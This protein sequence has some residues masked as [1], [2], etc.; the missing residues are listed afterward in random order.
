MSGPD[1]VLVVGVAHWSAHVEQ[2][3]QILANSSAPTIRD[4]S[5]A[6][7][8]ADDLLHVTVRDYWASHPEDLRAALSAAGGTT[9]GDGGVQSRTASGVATPMEERLV[10]T[11]EEAAKLLGISRSFAYEAVQKGDIPS[12]R[13]GR[14]ILVPK[15]RLERYLSEAG[16]LSPQATTHPP[17]RTQP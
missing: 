11:V 14:R 17:V 12:M 4:P 13:I 7:P 3:A 8:E 9:A 1:E 10:Y 16:S 6:S 2:L 5:G 15:S